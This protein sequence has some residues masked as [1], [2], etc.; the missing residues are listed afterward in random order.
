[1]AARSEID[2]IIVND[3]IDRAAAEMVELLAARRAAPTA[4]GTDN[5]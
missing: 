1:M 3:T 4:A 2:C 5:R